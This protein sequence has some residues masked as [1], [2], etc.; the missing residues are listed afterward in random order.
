MLDVVW[1]TPA[2]S[3]CGKWLVGV[4]CTTLCL[5]SITITCM[6]CMTCMTCSVCVVLVV[7]MTIV[8]AARHLGCTSTLTSLG[9][10]TVVWLF[11]CLG[12]WVVWLLGCLGCWVVWVVWLLGCWVVWLRGR[13]TSV[14]F[15]WTATMS[16]SRSCSSMSKSRWRCSGSCQQAKKYDSLKAVLR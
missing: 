2:S 14:H 1:H 5:L 15:C 12:C 8:H 9:T 4:L 7:S 13:N 16:L 10:A 6:T 3:A 11:G